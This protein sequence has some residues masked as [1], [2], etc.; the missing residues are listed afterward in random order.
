[1]II[2][3]SQMRKNMVEC[4]L[5]PGG[6][7]QPEVLQAFSTVPREQYVPQ[8]MRPCAYVDEDVALPDGAFLMEPLVFGRM[9][10]AA[11]PRYEDIVLNVGDMTGYSSAVLS[12]LVTTIVRL[13]PNDTRMNRAQA[14]WADFDFCNIAIIKGDG[15]EG[16]ARH[17][18]YS[19]I[20]INGAVTELPQKLL[21]Q[22]DEGGR[23][24]YIL[25]PPG[26]KVGCLVLAE[27][28]GE[29]IIC[30]RVIADA[31]TPYLKEFEPR[32]FFIF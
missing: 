32:P 13:E 16:C 30:T 2:N 31:A 4:Q 28:T 12:N 25:R 19:L 7:T 22:L 10:Q 5:Q 3:F 20:I 6:V 15:R 14:A 23:L 9:L 26:Q 21:D 29:E 1:M 11:A 27:K 18:P 17:A 8:V 24:V